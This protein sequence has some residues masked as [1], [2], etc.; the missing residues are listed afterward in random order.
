MA[1]LITPGLSGTAA[2]PGGNSWASDLVSPSIAH[3]EAQYGATSGA[4]DRPHPELRFTITPCPASII[5][6]TKARI[7]LTT[8]LMFTS[9]SFENSAAGT[10]HSGAGWF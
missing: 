1:V 3:F 7:T 5:A 2:R 9:T 4:V 10:S 6:G 8:P